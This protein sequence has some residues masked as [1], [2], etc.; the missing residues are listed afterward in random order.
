MEYIERPILKDVIK[1][2]YLDSFDI[3]F[4]LECIDD[5]AGSDMQKNRQKNW[6][7]RD[8]AIIVLL[9]MTVMRETALLEINIEDIDFDNKT[10]KVIDKRH[11]THIYKMNETIYNASIDWI[12]DRK[13]KLSDKEI[14]A[15]FISNRK[16]RLGT[17]SLVAIVEKYSLEGLGYKISTHKLRAAFCT[18]LYKQTKDIE[19]VRR[20][21][22]NSFIETTQRYVVDDDNAK[23]EAAFIMEK[24]FEDFKN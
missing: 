12:D 21:V 24:I 1:R 14:D 4:L 9:A 2:K 19:F 16:Q 20:A 11:K 6:K 15:L 18:I 7:L 5:G 17:K 23:D 22:G 8:K 13:K 3:H 10:I